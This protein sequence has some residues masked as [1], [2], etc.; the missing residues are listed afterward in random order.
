MKKKLTSVLM[1]AALSAV[2]A[3]CSSG[4]EETTAADTA[5]ETTAA[6]EAE[7]EAA[8][9]ETQA[10]EEETSGEETEGAG[11]GAKAEGDTFIVGF[12]QDFP[13]MGFLGDDG[14][15]TGFDLERAPEVADRLGLVYHID[16]EMMAKAA[17]IS[18]SHLP[19]MLRTWNCKKEILN[20]SVMALP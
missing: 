14:E 5:A 20:V 12:D 4:G 15:Y 6:T 1:A 7:T 3:A 10:E 11:E 16:L 19:G 18:R 9:E 17:F 8:G 13:P 2:L